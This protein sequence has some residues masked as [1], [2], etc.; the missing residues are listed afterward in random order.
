MET[1][2]LQ[3]RSRY[4][5][6]KAQQPPES[7]PTEVGARIGV[8]KMDVWDAEAPF[9]SGIYEIRVHHPRCKDG[10]VNSKKT[11]TINQM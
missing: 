9:Q 3:R 7:V 6:Q 2:R 8:A 4:R 10:R 5:A 1:N 11:F